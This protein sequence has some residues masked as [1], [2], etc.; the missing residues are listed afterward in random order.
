MHS[1]TLKFFLLSIFFI[2]PHVNADTIK[3]KDGTTLEGKILEESPST[4][5]IEYNVNKSIKDIKS[6]NRSEIKEIEKVSEDEIASNAIK[7]LLPT[8]DLLSVDD[9]NKILGDKPAKFLAQYPS[10]KHKDSVQKIIAEIEKEKAITE[11][12]GIK[13]NGKWVTGIEAAKDEYNHQAQVL[14]VKIIKANKKN[15]YSLALD[16]FDELQM[17][18]AYSLAYNE[19]IPLIKEVLPKYDTTL[20]REEKAYEVRNKERED[21]Y[22]S[23]EEEDKKRTEAA[24]QSGMKKFQLRKQEAKELKKIWLPVNKWDL[25]SIRDARRTIVKETDKLESLDL[26]L[27]GSTAKALSAAFS[28]FAEKELETTTSQLEIAKNNGA[29]GKAID[30]LSENL[31][32]SLKTDAE[33]KKA[34]AIATAAAEAEEAAK[35]EEEAKEEKKKIAA[36]EKAAREAEEAAAAAAEKAAREASTKKDGISFQ[37]ILMILVVILIGITICAKIFFKPAEEFSEEE[38]LQEEEN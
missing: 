34:A 30:K 36:A 35:K 15:N 10:S 23:M 24:F 31:E 38:L 18:Y 27:S 26:A 33:A 13:L 29:R 5:K 22:K 11:S 6:I 14:A 20:S 12:G 32:N 8:D 25:E 7:S 1:K 21:Q 17:N 28:A 3:L 37:T 16:H 9:Y 2:A 19:I 4:I